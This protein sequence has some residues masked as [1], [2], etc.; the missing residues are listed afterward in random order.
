MKA[1]DPVED[2][3]CT[4]VHKITM[5]NGNGG[6]TTAY[7][8]NVERV[9]AWTTVASIMLGMLITIGGGVFT[10]VQ[11]GIAGEVRDRMRHEMEPGGVV[12]SQVEEC[13]QHAAQEAIEEVQGVIQDDLDV[14]DTRMLEQRDRGIR[15]EQS[16][17]NLT[18]QVDENQ[19][20]IMRML[21]QGGGGG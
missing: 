1:K 21:R 17:I 9:K 19:E 20:E 15:V 18:D 5:S 10:A 7:Q 12:R 13:A 14:L 6:K 2:R 8:V 11:L 4:G 3:R 16:V